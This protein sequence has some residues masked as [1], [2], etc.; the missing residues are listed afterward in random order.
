MKSLLLTSLLLLT[1]NAKASGP[2]ILLGYIFDQDGITLQVFS[3]GCTKKDSWKFEK[4]FSNYTH[5]LTFY[6]KYQDTCL[7]I[8]RYGEQI[9]FTYEELGMEANPRFRILNPVDASRKGY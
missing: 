1:L 7:A 2:E 8:V 4:G 5:T 6:R 3:G 9:H